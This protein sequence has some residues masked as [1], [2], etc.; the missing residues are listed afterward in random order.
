M[1]RDWRTM[2]RTAERRSGMPTAGL[3]PAEGERTGYKMTVPQTFQRADIPQCF[4]TVL[5]SPKFGQN[6]TAGLLRPKFGSGAVSELRSPLPKPSETKRNL[7][8]YRG[9]SEFATVNWR[10]D[11]AGCEH[12]PCG[13]AKPLV[14]FRKSEFRLVYA[15]LHFFPQVRD[16]ALVQICRLFRLAASND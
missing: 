16:W 8:P 3:D 6:E 1:Q 10:R 5:I 7:G 11:G 12:S 2:L 14:R 15:R 13:R 9:I 4:P